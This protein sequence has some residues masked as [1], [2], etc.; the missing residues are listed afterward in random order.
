MPRADEQRDRDAALLAL[1]R[2]AGAHLDER[3]AIVTVRGELRVVGASGE[4][5]A[6]V[7]PRARGGFYVEGEPLVVGAEAARR[8]EAALAARLPRGLP[9]QGWD[10]P[11]DRGPGLYRLAEVDLAGVATRAFDDVDV[12]VAYLASTCA[13]DCVF[14]RHVDRETD[15][16]AERFALEAVRRGDDDVRGAYV[17]LGGPEPTDAP[18]VDEWVRTLRVAGASTIAMIGT[19]EPLGER[20]RA[21]ALRDAGLSVIALPLYG[22]SAAAH[23][24]IVR[25]AGAFDRLQKVLESCRS[26]GIACFLHTLMLTPELDRLDEL[27]AFAA[28]RDLPLVV[29]LPRP[30]TSSATLVDADALSTAARR[31]PVLGAPACLK[32][33]ESPVQGTSL[34]ERFG[35]MAIYLAVQAGSFAPGCGPCA[36]RASCWGVPAGVLASLA[37]RLQ[38]LTVGG[39]G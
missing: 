11:F 29:G 26:E 36:A 9:S 4:V 32:P 16:A 37:D 13:A 2:D 24:P 31:L 19:A 39:R 38:P 22:S 21:R 14:C 15:E 12:R 18:L 28:S 34:L 30:K 3:A 27:R 35:P 10:A 33:A 17:C 5:H 8:A 7:V 20:G 23:D 6:R 25:R 1:L